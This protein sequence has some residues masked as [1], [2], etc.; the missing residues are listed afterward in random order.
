MTTR[1]SPSSE[2]MRA[3]RSAWIVGGTTISPSDAVLAHHREH[4]LDVERV[5]RRRHGDPLAEVAREW[6]V[7]DELGP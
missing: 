5:T 7:G 3:W 1:T 2:S 6:S 4:L